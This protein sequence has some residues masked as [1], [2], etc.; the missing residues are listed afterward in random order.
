M[1]RALA[2]LVENPALMHSTQ[3]KSLTALCNSLHRTQC[4]LLAS[5]G[6]AHLVHLG[7]WCQN[8]IKTK[9]EIEPEAFGRM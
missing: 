9:K 1:A 8:L 2:A 4:P 3:V 6:N 5:T 7:R